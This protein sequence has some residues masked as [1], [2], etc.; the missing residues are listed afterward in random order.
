MNG[1]QVREIPVLLLLVLAGCNAPSEPV[2]RDYNW[3]PTRIVSLDYCA[4][5]YVLKFSDREQILAVSPEAGASYS[6][7]RESAAGLRAVRANAEDVLLLQPDL[8]VRAYGG[9]PRAAAFFDRAGI[10]VVDIGWAGD[11]D[12][13]T[14]N[15]QRIADELGQSERG[16]KTVATMRARLAAIKSTNTHQSALYLTPSG[17]TTGSGSM[18]DE[19]LSVAGF[20]NFE[21][22]AGWHPLPLERLAYEQPDVVAAAFFEAP[23][24]HLGAWT[25]VNHPV[26]KERLLQQPRVALQGSWTTCGGWFL[27]D[28]IEALADGASS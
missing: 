27:L 25:P 13:V 5:Q 23:N 7:M 24:E 11:L 4:D 9:G 6:Y 19:M 10:P 28:A 1:R 17:Y 12:G 26:A 20:E 8:V 18:I 22:R 16:A 2:A 21:P 14:Q 3:A 15:I